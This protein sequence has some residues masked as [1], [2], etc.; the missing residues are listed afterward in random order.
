MAQLEVL[1][2]VRGAVRAADLHVGLGAPLSALD[3]GPDRVEGAVHVQEPTVGVRGDLARAHVRP[4]VVRAAVVA[5]LEV[6]EALEHRR[7]VHHD[8]Q[9]QRERA[10][11]GDGGVVAAHRARRV[12]GLLELRDEARLVQRG[13]EG[14]A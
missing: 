2:V 3:R 9:P 7:L 12:G 4:R 10:P 1:Q 5:V 14:A 6:G 8:R 13:P 11:R